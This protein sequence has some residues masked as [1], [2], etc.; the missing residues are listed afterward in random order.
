MDL[1]ALE[2]CGIISQNIYHNLDTD[3]LVRLALNNNEGK[4][5]KT[6][7]LL[8]NTGEYTG[9]APND[10][11]IVLDDIT[12][13][14]VNWGKINKPI[15]EEIFSNLFKKVTKYL[16][17]K[18]IYVFDGFLGADKK[19]QMGFRTI[20][21]MATSSLFAHHM[22]IRPSEEELSSFKEDFTI[23]CA[24]NF[25][26]DPSIDKVNSSAAIIINFTRKIILIVGT[27]Y[28][29]EIKKSMFSVMNFYLPKKDVLPMH[30]SANIGKDNDVCIFFGLSGTGKTTLSSEP[31]RMLIGDDEHGYSKENV[32]NFEGGCYAKTYNLSKEKEPEIFSA[33]K[34][35]TLVENVVENPLTGDF[36]FNDKSISENS[37]ASYPIDYLPSFVIPSVGPKPKTIIFLSADAF[38][39]LPPVS[40]LNLNQA[41][42]YF[43]SGYT[44]KL[45]GT[46]KGVVEP[47][48]TFSSCFG[49]PF[50]PLNP[51]VYAKMLK[52]RII[53]DNVKVYLVNT[54]WI[55]G[56]YGQG[57]RIPLKYTRAIVTSIL[58]GEI[59][60]SEF[61]KDPLFNLE[62]PLYIENVP[63]DILVPEKAWKNH[64][65]YIKTS[66][67]L[68][69][70]FNKNIN[71]YSLEE[72]IINEGPKK[73]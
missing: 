18:T 10:R 24:P 38:G 8:I 40:K 16:N 64:D 57:E 19:Y 25:K 51:V 50:L 29:G 39:V 41:M 58:N 54:G 65:E 47:E 9:R 36:I 12:K 66:H 32:F 48:A 52:E 11:F 60:K 21:E 37:R 67:H 53:N 28:S 71:K 43:I 55:N 23:I 33:I 44:S 6:G 69:S 22:L 70:L 3:S 59:E 13:D 27:R 63:Q 5:N 30:C 46:E 2:K 14:E 49:E 45:S 34:E 31:N 35:G 68:A 61:I 73:K 62:I 4:L 42:Y 1:L 72:E 26:C 15:S 7:A 20:C 17:D 56:Q